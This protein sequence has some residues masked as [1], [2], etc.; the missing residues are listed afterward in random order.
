MHTVQLILHNERHSISYERHAT[1]HWLTAQSP[2]PW[3]Q[4]LDQLSLTAKRSLSAMRT[5]PA[6]N[7]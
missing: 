7:Q 3:A 2:L 1:T 5:L 6:L 4:L